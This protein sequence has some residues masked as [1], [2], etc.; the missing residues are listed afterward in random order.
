MKKWFAALTVAIF[1]L[2]GWSQEGHAQLGK[3]LF[4]KIHQIN[5]SVEKKNWKE[6]EQQALSLEKTYNRKRWKL[7]FLGDEAEYEGV[8]VYIQKLKSAIS[9]KDSSNVKIELAEIRATLQNIYT[10]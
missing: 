9:S 3:D 6:A 8:D 2:G 10:F 5:Q 4:Q 1:V 7:Q